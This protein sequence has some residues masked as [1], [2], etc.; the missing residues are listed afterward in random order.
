[1]KLAQKKEHA[2]L[3]YVRE[4]LS[5]K[6]I[7]ERVEVAEKTINRWVNENGEEWKRLRTSIFITKEEQLRR[8]YQQLDELNQEIA[9]RKEGSKFAQAK[10]AD[11]IVKLTAAAR[12]LESDASLSEIVEVAK[13][14]LNWLR[15]LDLEKAREIS[16]LFDAFIK[17]QLRK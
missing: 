8:I 1:M 7:A 15:P 5:Q 2:R 6:E 13:R 11:V 9:H 3:L 10:E 12:A 16:A 17:D 4:N 14:F